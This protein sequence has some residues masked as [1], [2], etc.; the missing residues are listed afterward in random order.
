MV[1]CFSKANISSPYST[2]QTSAT[3]SKQF[4]MDLETKV[5]QVYKNQDEGESFYYVSSH[6][7]FL[8]V[9]K[10]SWFKRA[11]LRQEDGQIWK[12]HLAIKVKVLPIIRILTL[13]QIPKKVLY[14]S[15]IRTHFTSAGIQTVSIRI[16]PMLTSILYTQNK[17]KNL[18]SVKYWSKKTM[19]K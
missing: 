6:E 1:N 8:N 16:Q 3:V 11:N 4:E 19:A 9:T 18:K 13:S 12:M 15:F 2:P 5:F 7:I 17:I 10:Y 14:C